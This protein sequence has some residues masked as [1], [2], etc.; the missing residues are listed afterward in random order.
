MNDLVVDRVIAAYGLDVARVLPVQ[1]GYR[2]KNYP[3]VLAS[4]GTVNLIFYKREPGIL[5]SIKSAN[6]IGNYLHSNSFPARHTYD[7]RIISLLALPNEQFAAVYAYLPGETIP[8][9]AYT[10]NRLKALGRTMSN[11]HAILQ[12]YKHNADLPTIHS[13]CAPI[14]QRIQAYFTDANVSGALRAKLSL[15]VNDGWQNN[16]KNLLKIS[17]QLPGQQALHMDFVRSNVLFADGGADISGVID[18]EKAAYG[19]P[20]FDIARTL[21]FLLVDCKYKTE[22]KIRKYFLSSGYAKYGEAKYTQHKVKING[23]V[24]DVLEYALDMFL[25]YDF[26]KFLRHNPYEALCQNQHFVRTTNILVNRGVIE[27]L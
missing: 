21:A 4:G 3:L 18:F 15:L 27:R 14:T 12:S 5:S 24:I 6:S 22:P 17:T 25:M 19:A 2:N 26:Y 8:W 11:M 23:Q 9:E 13:V 16:A 20:V 7:R 1:S 10:M